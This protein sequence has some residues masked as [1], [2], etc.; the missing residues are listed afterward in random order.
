M[1]P[2]SLSDAGMPESETFDALLS[3]KGRGGNRNSYDLYKTLRRSSYSFCSLVAPN[4]Y[5]RFD[6]L[7]TLSIRGTFHQRETDPFQRRAVSVTVCAPV[8]VRVRRDPARGASA[9]RVRNRNDRRVVAGARS[10]GESEPRRRCPPHGAHH[11]LETALRWPW[12]PGSYQGA[13][14]GRG[15]VREAVRR[16]AG[17]ATWWPEGQ[18]PKPRSPGHRSLSV[19]LHD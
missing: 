10:A 8:P 12:R 1:V 14:C 11:D 13:E 6:S 7:F 3:V 16:Q 15:S 2:A 18:T 4:T 5:R 9:R 19:P 17:S